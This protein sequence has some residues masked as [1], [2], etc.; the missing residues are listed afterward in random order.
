LAQSGVDSLRGCDS[1]ETIEDLAG[2]LL[3]VSDGFDQNYS[4]IRAWRGTFR[5]TETTLITGERLAAAVHRAS[6]STAPDNTPVRSARQS[7]SFLG[8][9]AVDFPGDRLFTAKRLVGPSILEDGKTERVDSV[10]RL[11]LRAIVT[12][13]RYYH[14]DPERVHG[15]FAG[16]DDWA[17]RRGRTAFRD[18][19]SKARNSE[20][21]DLT[22]PRRF[23]WVQGDVAHF[24]GYF[25]DWAHRLASSDVPDSIRKTFSGT[26]QTTPTGQSYCLI[27]AGHQQLIVR[28]DV[29]WNVT[30]MK[31]FEPRTDRLLSER[32]IRY[33]EQ[34]G[35]FVPAA[36]VL[37][38]LDS[39][40]Q[41][42]F[43]FDW[44]LIESELNVE[45][46]DS[47]FSLQHLGLEEG[48][49]LVDRVDQVG[50]VYRNGRLVDPLPMKLAP[51]A[52]ARET[53]FEPSP[54][55]AV[56]WRVWLSLVLAAC[57]V[58]VWLIYSRK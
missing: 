26:A 14:F 11:S 50:Y 34:D 55:A 35:V 29:G 10:D 19:L 25:R 56:H 48:E 30:L 23:Y 21:S 20:W 46:D 43:D 51:E 38:V 32:E 57:T 31:Q 18:P 27:L 5:V 17:I 45:F 42:Y 4:R 3:R 16:L 33:R 12:P 44:E 39:D 54:E 36:V 13:D 9:F 53:E 28:S 37:R 41:T 15:A 8:E 52:A 22:D 2:A 7:R 47:S 58:G 40:G 1:G 6:D 24:G 49:R